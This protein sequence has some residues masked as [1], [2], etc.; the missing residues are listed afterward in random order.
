MELQEWIAK[1]EEKAGE[2]YVKKKGFSFMF[3]PDK[4]FCELGISNELECVVVY[5]V[6][7]DIKAWCMVIHSIMQLCGYRRMTTICIR[8]IKP[9]MRLLGLKVVDSHET[10]LGTAYDV[11][12]ENGRG[13]VTP[14]KEETYFVALEVEDNA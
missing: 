8:H 7:G 10:E 3:F 12:F 9:Y 4:G 11:V 13:S 1:Y 5:R 6:C 14:I 2:K